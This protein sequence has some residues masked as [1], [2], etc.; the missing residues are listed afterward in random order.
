MD[1]RVLKA[2]LPCHLAVTLSL[3]PV[4][5]D[6][7]D[8]LLVLF[9]L[10]AFVCSENWHWILCW[11][12][13][14]LVMAFFLSFFSVFNKPDILVPMKVVY[15]LVHS[16]CLPIAAQFYP[17]LVHSISSSDKILQRVFWFCILWFFCGPSSF[18]FY[19]MCKGCIE[20]PC[21]WA[22]SLLLTLFLCHA[23]LTICGLILRTLF[24]QFC[25]CSLSSI[26]YIHRYLEV[27]CC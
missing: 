9:I 26:T 24:T 13:S 25:V 8:F 5:W 16:L 12:I 6:Y 19:D 27:R 4:L 1:P 21:T 2:C 7:L 11:H 23:Q 22:Y 14:P 20:I 18:N 10:R 15:Q 3:I 17:V